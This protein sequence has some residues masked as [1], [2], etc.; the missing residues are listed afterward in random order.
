M[1]AKEFFRPTLIRITLAVLCLGLVLK[2]LVPVFT[3][4]EI[5]PCKI[6]ELPQARLGF[7]PINP[8]PAATGIDSHYLFCSACDYVYQFIYMLLTIIIL[9]YAISCTMVS[10]YNRYLRGRFL[11]RDR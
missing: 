1:H 4:I 6:Y 5:I 11:S 8:D 2:F 9:P 3:H 10:A 7:C